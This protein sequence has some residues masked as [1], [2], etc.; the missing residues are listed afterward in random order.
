MS[1][2]EPLDSNPENS[3]SLLDACLPLAALVSLLSL[4]VYIFGEDS[5]YGP[6][7]IALLLCAS[8]AAL[9]GM[10]NGITY[11][12]LEKGM[13]NG[14]YLALNAIFILLAVGALIGTWILAGTVPSMIYYGIQILSPDWF[15]AACCL[16]CAIVGLSIG[17]SWTTAGT[18]GIA[19]IGIASALD[20]SPYITAGA[21]ISGAYF[22]DK[23]SPLSDT[24]NLAAA[25]VSQDLFKHIR[26]MLW[27]TI[28][29]FLLSIGFFT[30]LGFTETINSKPQKEVEDLLLALNA[31]FTLSIIT[32]APLLLLL[33]MAWR[34]IPAYPTLLIGTL[35]GAIIALFFQ[36]QA[37]ANLSAGSDGLSQLKGIWVS[38]FDGYSSSSS[39]ESIANLLSKG[40]MSSMLNTVWLIVSAMAFGGIMERAGLLKKL[41][42]WAISGVQSTGSLISITVLTCLGMNIT[43]ADQYMSVIIPGRMFR[44]AFE[45]QGLDGLNLSRTLED[46]ATLSSALIPW[47]TCGA[48]MSAT[49]GVAVW[50]FTNGGIGGYA[51]FAFFNLLCPILAIAYGFFAFKQLPYTP[52]N[53]PLKSTSPAAT[54]TTQP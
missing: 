13:F 48:Y 22:G 23:M 20:L 18:L 17:S 1:S 4:S 54:A 33:T 31:E 40:G 36:P 25:V 7:Q 45:K 16:I 42:R 8:I 6:N 26:H 14:V 53:A 47:N 52:A 24:T 28:P 38:M 30:I 41:V 43:A 2:N 51:P 27:T 21:I 15:Y 46:S 11:Q 9:I 5:S 29:A 44:D 49:L 50:D 10:K 34:K 12:Q 37:L 39:N 3:A 19:L 32:L 35:A